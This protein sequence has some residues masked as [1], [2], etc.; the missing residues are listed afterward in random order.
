MAGEPCRPRWGSC[1]L[2]AGHKGPHSCAPPVP[3]GHCSTCAI[4]SYAE[5]LACE[6]PD[7][8]WLNHRAE[9]EGGKS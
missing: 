4:S 5:F 7:C 9:Q 8:A 6:E 3:Q 2:P 1:H